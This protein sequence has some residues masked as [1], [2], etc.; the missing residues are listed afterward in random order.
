MPS[1]DAG[2]S[3]AQLN[4]PPGKY[5][6]EVSAC[7]LKTSSGGNEM[8][9]LILEFPNH[10]TV[11]DYLVFTLKTGWKI[12]QFREALGDTI[13]PGKVELKA[14]DFLKRKGWALLKVEN[15][16]KGVPRNKVDSY[17]KHTNG[18]AAVVP[19][20]QGEPDDLPY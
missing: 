11:W 14:T 10:V 8:F 18:T 7:K 2:A 9:E 19:V 20:T 12:D 15:D 4:L 6:F 5:P 13:K 3:A 16:D 1:Y 17:I